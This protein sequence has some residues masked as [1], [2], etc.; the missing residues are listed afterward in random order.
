VVAVN[1][2]RGQVDQAVIASDRPGFTLRSANCAF[3]V[4]PDGP[5][6]CEYGAPPSGRRFTTI[7]VLRAAAP[8]RHLHRATFQACTTNLSGQPDPA[9]ADNCRSITITLV[10]RP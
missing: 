7:Y 4:S 9:P 3:G 2:G 1:H 8:T 10:G 6:D 5:N